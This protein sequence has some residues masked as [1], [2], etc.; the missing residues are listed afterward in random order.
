MAEGSTTQARKDMNYKYITSCNALVNLRKIMNALYFNDLQT[1]QLLRIIKT[2]V[3][4]AL[5]YYFDFNYLYAEMKHVVQDPQFACQ[6]WLIEKQRDCDQFYSSMS[7]VNSRKLKKKISREKF[8]KSF[9]WRLPIFCQLQRQCISEAVIVQNTSLPFKQSVS[10]L[11]P[12]TFVKIVLI[13]KWGTI[14]LP[15]NV[16]SPSVKEKQGNMKPHFQNLARF[17]VDGHP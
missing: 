7:Y 1:L 17:K 4:I 12:S 14:F 8:Q 16:E 15:K 2:I 13:I 11:C 9:C 6:F 10:S 5:K 3:A